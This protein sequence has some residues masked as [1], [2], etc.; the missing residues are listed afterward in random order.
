MNKEQIIKQLNALRDEGQQLSFDM[1]P[2]HPLDENY[3]ERTTPEWSSWVQRV[4]NVITSCFKQESAPYSL[5][6]VS[7]DDALLFSKGVEQFNYNKANLNKA[8][9]LAVKALDDDLFGEV[10]GQT[11]NPSNNFDP[12]SIFIVHGHNHEAKNE[13]ELFLKELG[14]KPIVLHRE[15]DEGQTI[16]EKFERHSNV[17]FAIVLLTPDDAVAPSHRDTGIKES[18][19]SR[20][21]Q[22]VIFEFGFF[23]GRLGRNRVCCLHQQP[24]TLPS[25]LSGL[26]YKPFK[27]HIEE[28]KYAI[29]KELKAAGYQVSL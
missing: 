6:S 5:I 28:V 26:I 19:E 24:V 7:V 25:D 2:R 27:A 13:L 15:A 17:G 9:E 14:L 11:T 3:A 10:I 22:N 4:Y 16:I 18:V 21:R 1:F 20:A 8:I 12:K 29:I 23:V